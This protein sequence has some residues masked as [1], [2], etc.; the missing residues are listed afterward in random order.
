MARP[1]GR[2]PAAT[3]VPA[4]IGAHRLPPRRPIFTRS[5]AIKLEQC[6]G[7][8]R[9]ETLRGQVIAPAA[10]VATDA[11]TGELL[12]AV[13]RTVIA[14]PSLQIAT[15]PLAPALRQSILPQGRV[16]PTPGTCCATF[17]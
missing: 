12:D 4:W 7:E 8:W 2:H 13:R 17:G 15:E 1:S 16:H 3:L 10:V 11:Y 6:G 9:I 14:V 5:A